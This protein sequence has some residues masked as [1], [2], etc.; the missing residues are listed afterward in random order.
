VVDRVNGLSIVMP[1]LNE[2]PRIEQALLAL[3][4]LRAG[5]HG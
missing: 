4:S 3:Q 2:A 1:V 5:G